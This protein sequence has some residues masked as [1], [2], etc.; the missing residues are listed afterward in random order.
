MRWRCSLRSQREEALA[1]EL[2]EALT[3]RISS[4]ATASPSSFSAA[5]AKLAAARPPG[6]NPGL[7]GACSP[8]RWLIP[9]MVVAELGAAMGGTAVEI[10]GTDISRE[11][12]HRA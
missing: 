1:T 12:M 11:M 7:V 2:V 9:R 6:R 3:Q 4:S 5:A 8:G 10:L